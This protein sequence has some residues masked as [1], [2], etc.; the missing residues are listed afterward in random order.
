MTMGRISVKIVSVIIEIFFDDKYTMI[1]VIDT[2]YMSSE[3]SLESRFD[4]RS[5]V[6]D[7]IRFSSEKTLK[8][9]RYKLFIDDIRHQFDLMSF[10]KYSIQRLYSIVFLSLI[11][12]RFGAVGFVTRVFKIVTYDF[13]RYFTFSR[14]VTLIGI[15]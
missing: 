7:F 3:Y 8:D 11:R 2:E 4:S 1:L 9:S 15:S 5:S 14:S 6:F 10:T 12:F 13:S